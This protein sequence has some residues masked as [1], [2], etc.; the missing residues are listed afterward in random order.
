M[1]KNQIEYWKLQEQKRANSAM[2]LENVRSNMAREHETE[3]ANRANEAQT[4]VRDANTFAINY[5]ANQEKQRSN[6]AQEALTMAYND[7]YFANLADRLQHDRNVLQE[8][9]RS[10]KARESETRRSNIAMENELQRSHRASEG[11][12]AEAQA[13]TIRSHYVNEDVA[14]QSTN[15]SK[16]NAMN[17]SRTA[18]IN[19]EAVVETQRHN[20][21]SE[22]IS[23][24][25]MVL[26]TVGQIGGAA[27][28]G[29]LA[30]R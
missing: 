29:A 10:N 8:T 1:T 30:R 12:Q 25:S 2:E 19:K 21:K 24:W 17:A 20:K 7:R 18:D 28:R 14:Q 9:T 26:G 15:I 3:R 11:L 13:E 16:L 4:K 6:M 27:V 23:T 5:A 22:S